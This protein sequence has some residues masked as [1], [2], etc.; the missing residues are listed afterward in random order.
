MAEEFSPP[1]KNHS[2]LRA[3]VKQDIMMVKANASVPKT[4]ELPKCSL[5]TSFNGRHARGPKKV[6]K[7][8]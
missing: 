2:S 3:A 1:L 5:I 4:T 7:R 6:Q 8:G